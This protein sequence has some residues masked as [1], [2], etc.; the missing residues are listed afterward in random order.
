[1]GE[2]D[3]NCPVGKWGDAIPIFLITRIVWV[4]LGGVEFLR[5]IEK[6]VWLSPKGSELCEQFRATRVLC[7]P[8]SWGKSRTAENDLKQ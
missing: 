3:H 2:H 8:T 4:V 1:M 5:G 7:L 6:R